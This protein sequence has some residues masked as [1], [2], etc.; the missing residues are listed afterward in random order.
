MKTI[1]KTILPGSFLRFVRNQRYGYFGPYRD[2]HTVKKMTTGYDDPIIL[3]KVK[4]SLMKVKIGQVA[5]ERD[6]VT[7]DSIQYSWPLLVALLMISG[8]NENCLSLIDF[9][10]SLGS[11]YFQNKQFLKHLKSVSWNIVEQPS[12]VAA[13]RSSFQ[14]HSLHFFENIDQC[15]TTEKP[16]AILLSSVVQYIE[17]PYDLLQNIMSYGFRYI[18]LDRTIFSKDGSNFVTLQ[19]VPPQ[20]YKASYPCWFLSEYKFREM[21]NDKYDVIADFDALGGEIKQNNLR[22]VH[23]GYILKHK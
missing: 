19:K 15:M 17:S 10:G 5:Y 13:G 16:F 7:F 8:E 1:I 23:K 12:F 14:D 3:A 4:D 22:A 6:S 21:I 11:S 20:I 18:I 9:G 2:W